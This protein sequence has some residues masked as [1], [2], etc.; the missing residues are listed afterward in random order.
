[1]LAVVKTPHTNLRI[2]GDISGAVLSVLKAEY[3]KKLVIKKEADDE[4]VKIMD[5]DWYKQQK[6]TMT[7]GKYLRVYRENK[8]LTQEELGQ[9][10]GGL[11]RHYVS[12]LETGNR[13]ISKNIAKIL[14]ELFKQPVTRFL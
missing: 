14:S 11:S 4:L 12:D 1:M 3:G 5:T 9:K 8:D 6:K 10:L 13:A 7:P 2:Q